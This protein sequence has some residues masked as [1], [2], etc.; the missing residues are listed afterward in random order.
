MKKVGMILLV[1]TLL[2]VTISAAEEEFKTDDPVKQEAYNYGKDIEELLKANPSK[3]E[4]LIS[5]YPE[6]FQEGLRQSLK[7]PETKAKLADAWTQKTES[8]KLKIS[9]KAKNAIWEALTPPERSNQLKEILARKFAKKF[10][11]DPEVVKKRLNSMK[12]TGDEVWEGN[13][14]GIKDQNKITAWIDVDDTHHT[15]TDIEFTESDVQLKFDT[16]IA[17]KKII[18]KKGTIN[19]FGEIVDPNG[20]IIGDPLQSGIKSIGFDGSTGKFN[21]KFENA[22]GEEATLS[23]GKE[24]IFKLI[25]TAKPDNADKLKKTI[26]DIYSGKGDAGQKAVLDNL[27]FDT[28]LS[29]NRN[30][31]LNVLY[32]GDYKNEGVVEIDYDNIGRLNAKLSNGGNIV[33]TDAAGDAR[34]LYKQFYSKN[35]IVDSKFNAGTSSEAAEFKFDYNGDIT[36]AKN[37][38]IDIANIGEI[39]TSRRDFVGT[40]IINRDTIIAEIK[41]QLKTGGDLSESLK[42]RFGSLEEIKN[43]QNLIETGEIKDLPPAIAEVINNRLNSEGTSTALGKELNNL[44]G[45]V[46]RSLENNVDSLVNSIYSPDPFDPAY[47]RNIAAESVRE[48]LSSQTKGLVSDITGNQEYL[49]ALASGDKEGIKKLLFETLNKRLGSD[50]FRPHVQALAEFMGKDDIQITREGIGSKVDKFFDSEDSK[51]SF[52]DKVKAGLPSAFRDDKIV[53]AIE[54]LY[55]SAATKLESEKDNFFESITDSYESGIVVD[56]EGGIVHAYGDKYIAFDSR[57]DLKGFTATSTRDGEDHP[58]SLITLKSNG[59]VIAQF[60]GDKSN[61]FRVVPNADYNSIDIIANTRASLESTNNVGR[62]TAPNQFNGNKWQITYPN[63]VT[64]RKNGNIVALGVP[65]LGYYHAIDMKLISTDP[66]TGAPLKEGSKILITNYGA[67]GYN[68]PNLGRAQQLG[69][70]KG[71]QEGLRRAGEYAWIDWFGIIENYARDKGASEGYRIATQQFLQGQDPK[72]AAEGIAANIIGGYTSKMDSIYASWGKADTEF[73]RAKGKVEYEHF[74]DTTL[75]QYGSLLPQTAKDGL[76]SSVQRSGYQN[77][78]NFVGSAPYS[79][80]IEVTPTAIRKS[81][82]EILTVGNDVSP[83]VMRT[84]FREFS[85]QV[86]PTTID[87]ST[88]KPIE[89]SNPVTPSATQQQTTTYQRQSDVQTFPTQQTVKKYGRTAILQRERLRRQGRL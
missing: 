3:Q 37:G 56:A 14:L 48:L 84:F 79:A 85:K 70:Q 10:D 19:K 9:D 68:D 46:T 78:A 54:S 83:E 43:L 67:T 55:A 49:N 1:V 15:I 77:I 71:V 30:N 8:G 65:E 21:V 66:E 76:A 75:S 36:A 39:H 80:T 33:S 26:E 73:G 28:K 82:G 20:I 86:K 69:V 87:Y 88:G 61:Y 64:T 4:E 60:D 5:D 25:E 81:T 63:V 18:L 44:F 6:A 59:N 2:I 12:L 27:K 32:G 52:R 41:T 11:L 35:G 31:K 72:K 47:E 40:D 7:D 22:G 17:K 53:D 57:S 58:H 62:L 51:L 24:E 38:I 23:I 29:A 42:Q 50:E 45:K 16:G 89:K 13:K 74:V 34:Q